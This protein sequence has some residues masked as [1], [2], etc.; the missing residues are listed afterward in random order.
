MTEEHKKSRLAF[1][2]PNIF[3]AL[4]MA[5]GF[6]SILLSMQGKFY[7]A[8]IVLLLGGIFDMVDGRVA[9][10]TGTQSA[11]GE[12]FD[13]MSDVISFGIAPAMLMY[14]RFFVDLGRVGMVVAFFYLLCGALRLCRFN[15]RIGKV[16]PNY[17]EGLPIPGSAI[18][19][20]SYTM[21]SLEFPGIF[22]H[23]YV[24]AAYTLF[25]AVL[26]VS[27][28][29][30]CSFKTTKWIKTRRKTVLG[31]IFVTL[32]SIF[33][34]EEVMVAIII[35]LYVFGSFIFFLFDKKKK[36]TLFNW[37]DE[38]ESVDA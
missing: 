4:N 18:A 26:M 20:L 27:T 19:L 10:L 11:F 12:Q 21:I 36:K 28:V 3:T 33:I 32:C 24:A 31:V 8:C 6:S 5:C 35:S 37:D 25:Y 14:T 9:R 15:T 17:F 7:L 16:D 22:F 29:P 2:L 34:Y 30:F 23:P 13:S 1:F 38:G